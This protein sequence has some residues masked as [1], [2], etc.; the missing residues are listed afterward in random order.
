M[1]A[2]VDAE[3]RCGVLVFSHTSH[4]PYTAVPLTALHLLSFEYEPSFQVDR[5]SELRRV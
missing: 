1:D 5:R 4:T 2:E 3:A